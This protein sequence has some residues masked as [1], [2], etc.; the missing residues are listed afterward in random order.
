MKLQ[1]EQRRRCVSTQHA[2]TIFWSVRLNAVATFQQCTMS[3]VVFGVSNY[4]FTSLLTW[5][6]QKKQEIVQI[7]LICSN[8]THLYLFG[9]MLKD[10]L[11][12][13]SSLLSIFA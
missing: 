1:T 5:L 3:S 4:E 9:R 8:K 6:R 11:V 2:A 10:I 7:R 13:L 12:Y